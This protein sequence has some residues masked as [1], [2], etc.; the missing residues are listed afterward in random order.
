MAAPPRSAEPESRGAMSRC[1]TGPDMYCPK[2]GARSLGPRLNSL[3][4][5]DHGGAVVEVVADPAG[6]TKAVALVESPGPG[7]IRV[8]VRLHEQLVKASL[9]GQIFNDGH[10]PA[11]ESAALARGIDRN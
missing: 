7:E 1:L 10:Q 3:G 5:D 11:S 8:L 6:L 4:I 9:P 2:G